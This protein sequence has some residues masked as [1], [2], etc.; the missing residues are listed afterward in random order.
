[1]VVP[2]RL[3]Y[4]AITSFHSYIRTAYDIGVLESLLRV[5][6]LAPPTPFVIAIVCRPTEFKVMVISSLQV[7]QNTDKATAIKTHTTAVLLSLLSYSWYVIPQ[8]YSTTRYG[9]VVF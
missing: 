4:S 1:M 7:V 8:T 6:R 3:D 5:A 2:V 9:G